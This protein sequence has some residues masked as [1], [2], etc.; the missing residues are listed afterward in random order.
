M[1]IKTAHKK[2]RFPSLMDA[3]CLTDDIKAE[4]GESTMDRPTVAWW[5]R[6][7]CYFPFSLI[8]ELLDYSSADKAGRAVNT[9]MKNGRS[10]EPE[11]H[12]IVSTLEALAE[13]HYGLG[14]NPFLFRQHE[15]LREYCLYMSAT[16]VGYR[17]NRRNGSWFQC[18]PQGSRL[19]VFT[20][21][22]DRAEKGEDYA[23]IINDY[24][25]TSNQ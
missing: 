21:L 1:Q 16:K 7:K 11:F 23:D 22:L 9:A 5:L 12:E 15:I 4:F 18:T 24:T 14:N 20:D 19:L 3:W 10:L 13:N 8:H 25:I 2:V 6:E 17:D